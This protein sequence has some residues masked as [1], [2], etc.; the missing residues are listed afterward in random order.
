MS[1][2]MNLGISPVFSKPYERKDTQK[3]GKDYRTFVKELRQML[4]DTLEVGEEKIFFKERAEGITAMGDRLFIECASTEDTKEVCGIYTEE[5]F[6]SYQGGVSLERIA[7]DVRRE[8]EKVK[9]GNLFEKTRNLLDYSKIKDDLFIRLINRDRNQK[10][11]EKAIY[12]TVGDIALVLY[13]RLGDMEGCI[14]SMK[15]RQ[16]YVDAWGIDK[17]KVFEDALINTYKMSPPRIYYWEKLIYDSDYEGENFMDTS[18]RF[19][20]RKDAIGN[21]LSTVKRTNGAVAVFLP[22]VAE[23]LAGLIGQDFYLVFTSIHE[24]MIHNASVVVPEDLEDVLKE[25]LDAATP[26]ED[27]LTSRIYR[28]CRATG[29]FIC[30]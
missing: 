29:S 12:R 2:C 9:K 17:D 24:V 4:L 30:V 6:E 16:E 25:T 27:Y 10:E 23:R 3:M 15:I 21:C 18:E 19:E 13:I 1:L 22:G 11:L 7:R 26:E 8:L 5:L 20:M 28:Y 14:T